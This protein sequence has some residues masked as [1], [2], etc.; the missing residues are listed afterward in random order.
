MPYDS[1]NW[2]IV[3]SG[4]CENW[5]SHNRILYLL[6]TDLKRGVRGE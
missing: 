2:V 4:I 1:S 5:Q 6:K 3:W